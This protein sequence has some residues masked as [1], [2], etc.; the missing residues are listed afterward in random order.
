VLTHRPQIDSLVHH[1]GDDGVVV[2]A[3]K[4]KTAVDESFA[5][6][7]FLKLESPYLLT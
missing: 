5:N 3:L 2:V 7:G 1:G 4:V 6:G